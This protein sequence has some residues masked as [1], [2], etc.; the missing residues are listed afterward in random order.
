MESLRKLEEVLK[1][2]ADQL[3]IEIQKVE[4]ECAQACEKIIQEKDNKIKSLNMEYEEKLRN[5]RRRLKTIYLAMYM[6]KL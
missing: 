6:V 4:K 1:R 2:D 3:I 5:I